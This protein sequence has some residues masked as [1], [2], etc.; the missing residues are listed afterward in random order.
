M[1]MI[2]IRFTYLR[3]RNHVDLKMGNHLT[4]ELR[5]QLTPELGNQL[6]LQSSIVGNIRG[7]RQ[8]AGSC[9][10]TSFLTCLPRI[11]YT[12]IFTRLSEGRS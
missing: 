11:S 9:S 1:P 8:P 4:L 3:V 6:A 7:P 10:S 5:N 12:M 2:L